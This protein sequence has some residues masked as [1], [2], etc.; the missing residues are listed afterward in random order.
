MKELLNKGEGEAGGVS[1]SDHDVLPEV[2][3]W[4]TF[5]GIPCSK[6]FSRIQ[7]PENMKTNFP[8][9]STGGAWEVER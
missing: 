1:L 3:K 5:A 7:L 4:L 8:L 9:R 2:L 6:D